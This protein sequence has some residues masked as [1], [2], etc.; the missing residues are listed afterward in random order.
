MPTQDQS[1]QL[2]P[3]RKELILTAALRT[4]A[5]DGVAGLSLRTV[6]TQANVALGSIAYYFTDKDGLISA[7]FHD[8]AQRSVEQFRSFYEGATT[9]EEARAATVSMLSA[10]AG[11][12]TDI[13][14]GSELYALSLRRPRHRMILLEWTRA[15]QGVM[16]TYFDEATTL[17]LDALYEGA[18]LHHAMHVGATSTERIALAVERLT[19]PE[20]FIFGKSSP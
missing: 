6:A 18:I 10:T 13:I 8:F 17:A 7:A 15:C 1:A 16:R 20:S 2:Q 11:S 12:R 3:Q 19:P 14:L 4:I 5:R 9:L